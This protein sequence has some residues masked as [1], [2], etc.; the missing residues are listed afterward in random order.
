MNVTEQSMLSSYASREIL[1]ARQEADNGRP[2][3][4][5]VG[6]R[7]FPKRGTKCREEKNDLVSFFTVSRLLVTGDTPTPTAVCGFRYADG[8]SPDA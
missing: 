8:I 4:D 6:K 5:V 3:G 2:K 7:S 1:S